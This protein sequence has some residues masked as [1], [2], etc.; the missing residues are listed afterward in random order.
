MPKVVEA[1]VLTSFDENLSLEKKITNITALQRVPIE[2]LSVSLEI[3]LGINGCAAG[4]YTPS[5]RLTNM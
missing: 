1:M 5:I 3:R 2:Y 4:I